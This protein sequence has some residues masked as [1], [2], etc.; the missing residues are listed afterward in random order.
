MKVRY[1][2]YF[3]GTVIACISVAINRISQPYI[4]AGIDRSRPVIVV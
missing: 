4:D 1:F 2:R 3:F